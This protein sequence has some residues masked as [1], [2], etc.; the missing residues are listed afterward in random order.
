M[1]Y[2]RSLLLAVAAA[3][4]P[5]SVGGEEPP[6]QKPPPNSGRLTG[7]R[8]SISLVEQ[9]EGQQTLV[10]DYRWQVH[11]KA[12][13]EVRLVPGRPSRTSTYAPLYFFSEYFKARNRETIYHCFD[14]AA[15][16]PVVATFSKDRLDFE[17]LAQRNSLGRPSVMVIAGEGGKNADLAT[18]GVYL[19]LDSW[20]LDDHTLTL[21]LPKDRFSKRGQLY[22]WFLRGDRALWEESVWWPGS[23]QGSA[24]RNTGETNHEAPKKRNPEK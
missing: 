23:E 24:S 9:R 21:D 15:E 4:L 11:D 18:M 22:V 3:L 10:V 1:Y 20:A 12:S 19:L 6:R 8:A 17:I 7:G 2:F 14:H 16:Q 5:V 13:V